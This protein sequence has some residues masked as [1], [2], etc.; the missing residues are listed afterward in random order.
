MRLDIGFEEEVLCRTLRDTMYL[1]KASGVLDA[2]HFGTKHHAWI[3][4]QIKEVWT[5]Y[6][7]ICTAKMFVARAK[8]DFLEPDDRAPYLRLV[9]KLL[10]K[11]PKTSVSA[12]DE[13]SRFVRLVN[14]QLALEKGAT[15][16]E[17]GKV[18]DVYR[19]MREVS[20]KDFKPRTYTRIKWIEEFEERQRER[21]HRKEHP[22]EYTSIPTGM[23]KLDAVIT[24]IQLGEVG[25][26]LGTTGRGK[27]ILLNN[28]AYNAVKYR[29]PT[30]YFGFEMPA[31][32]I[33]QRQDARWLQMPYKKFKDYAFSPSELREIKIRLERIKK[34]WTSLFQIF[35]MPV[36]SATIQTVTS[37]L[38]DAYLETG[39]KPKLL[40]FDSADHLLPLGRSESYR[41]DQANVYWSVKGLAEDDGYAIWS[42]TQAKQEYAKKLITAEG[43]SESYDKARIADIMV[44]L[45][46][47]RKATRSTRVIDEEDDDDDDG[48]SMITTKGSLL[49]LYLA[50][51][52]DGVSKISIPLD[53]EFEKMLVTEVGE[54]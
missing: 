18:D 53:V 3:W 42:T 20:Q 27:S 22:E 12:L 16:L 54:E 23:E 41:L 34:S 36:R 43:G 45:N 39:F 9:K 44:T 5:T 2:H 1:K 26:I 15:A 17:K 11:K 4:T 35:S 29:F 32:Q 33:A 30:A 10:K 47:P 51:Y 46:E 13:L 8:R 37:A 31:R 38:D 6:R 7:E 49:E 24:G 14:A 19:V 52:R 40:L 25:L 48:E 21:K 28:F 50:K